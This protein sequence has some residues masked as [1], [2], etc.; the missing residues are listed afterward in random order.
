MYNAIRSQPIYQ[1]SSSS[2][3]NLPSSAD[4]SRPSL[5]LSPTNSPYS[6]WSTGINRTASRR[7]GT[8]S[9]ASSQVYGGSSSKRSSVRGFGAL[10]GAN[11]S[12]DLVRSTSPTPST[13]TSLSD[14]QW[15]TAFGVAASSHHNVP[16]IGFAN[17]L[18]HTIIREQQEDDTRSIASSSISV[19][20]EELALLG[21][22]WAKEGILQRKH[23]WEV[24]GKR[25]KEKNWLKAF[26]VVS[27][28]ELRMFRFDGG[29]GSSGRKGAG[30]GGG[31]WTV[32]RRSSF[33]R[34]ARVTLLTISG[35][36]TRQTSDRSLS[37]TPFAQQCLLPA[38]RA[39]DLTAS[40]SPSLQEVPTSSKPARP[41]SSR[42]GFRRAITG[43][44]DCPVNLYREES[45]MSNMGG[46]RSRASLIDRT[47]VRQTIGTRSR[48]SRV[49]RVDIRGCLMLG[50]HSSLLQ[51]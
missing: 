19:T 31:D 13:S 15:S 47:T 3:L 17:S 30:M 14:E 44:L 50:R 22:P 32:R 51:V 5:A 34:A 46:T 42:N 23:Y 43:P 45:A 27:Q 6:T 38:T 35:S 11:S 25:S 24:Q 8:S 36:R 10:L 48:A 28:G 37:F 41:T 33:L 26:V 7:S 16:T 1:S 4:P 18:S 39:I 9:A 49:A 21:A 20:D 2:T 29:G 12:L 40:S